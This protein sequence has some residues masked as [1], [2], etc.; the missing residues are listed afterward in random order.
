ML[1]NVTALPSAA[2]SDVGASKLAHTLGRIRDLPHVDEVRLT[3]S[4]P[5]M[6]RAWACG[7]WHSADA[8]WHVERGA[9]AHEAAERLGR[10]L[11]GQPAA[12]AACRRYPLRYWDL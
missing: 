1:D 10:A 11:L 6:P 12:F 7:A 4:A 8:L 3:L 2:F 9:T 5:W